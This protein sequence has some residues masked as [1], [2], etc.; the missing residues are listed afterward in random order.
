[1]R[2]VEPLRAPSYAAEHRADG[3]RESQPHGAH[4]LVH[5]RVGLGADAGGAFFAATFLAGAFLAAAFFAGAFFAG[6]FV[7]AA[8]FFAGGFL[9]AD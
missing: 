5:T 4:E 9:A 3:V 2:R 6:A 7:G 1:M 8:A